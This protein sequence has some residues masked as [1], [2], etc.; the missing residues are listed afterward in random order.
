[1][2]RLYVIGQFDVRR[3]DPQQCRIELIEFRSLEPSL[4][5]VGSFDSDP[6]GH[7]S[8]FPA[9]VRRERPFQPL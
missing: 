1:M 7:W 3:F 8:F 4:Q 9:N 2:D 6:S 5:F